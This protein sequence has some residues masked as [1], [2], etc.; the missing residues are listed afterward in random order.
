MQTAFVQQSRA[1]A[2]SYGRIVV[3]GDDVDR[4]RI[5]GQITEESIPKMNRLFA[6]D[7]SVEDIA[8][9]ENGIGFLGLG[10][11]DDLTKN[12]LLVLDQ[13]VLLDLL[14]EV[15]VGD[16]EKFHREIYPS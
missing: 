3:S 6:R 10:D 8:G 2:H 7:T 11:L 12:M 16:M 9:D 1:E 15:K 13:I 5:G 4:D 14:A